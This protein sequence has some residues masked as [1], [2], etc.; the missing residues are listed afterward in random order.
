MDKVLS[1]L[2]KARNVAHVHHWKVKSFSLH[3]ALGELYEA[4]IGFAD[5][6]AEMYMGRY[7]TDI[8]IGHAHHHD[9]YP[10]DGAVPSLPQAPDH[11]CFS[12]QDPIEFIRQL[13]CCLE[14]LKLCIPQDGFLINKYEELQGLVSQTKYKMENLR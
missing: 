2:F 10:R 11:H 3:L 13:D 1:I 4:L 6:L 9:E 5:S 12:E 8:T 7:G 14:E